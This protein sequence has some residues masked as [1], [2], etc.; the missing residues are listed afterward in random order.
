M[1]PV[2]VNVDFLRSQFIHAPDWWNTFIRR[3]N[4]PSSGQFAIDYYKRVYNLNISRN[5]E[6]GQG[7]FGTY[8]YDITF[9]SEEHFCEFLLKYC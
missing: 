9:E 3:A 7:S 5:K 2:V 6:Y 8:E 4:C 1:K